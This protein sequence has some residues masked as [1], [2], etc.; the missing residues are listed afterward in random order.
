MKATKFQ[1]LLL[2]QFKAIRENTEK[3]QDGGFYVSVFHAKLSVNTMESL[4]NKGLIEYE[5]YPENKDGF[6]RVIIMEVA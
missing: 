6:Y 3:N 4:T 1:A 2:E 5:R